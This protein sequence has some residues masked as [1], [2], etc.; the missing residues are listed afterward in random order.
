MS[1]IARLQRHQLFPVRLNDDHPF[2]DV[3]ELVSIV[4]VLSADR[5]RFEIGDIDERLS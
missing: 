1:G 4:G 3:D 5:S 2:E